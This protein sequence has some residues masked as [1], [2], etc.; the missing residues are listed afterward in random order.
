MIGNNIVNMVSTVHS[1]CEGEDVKVNRRRSGINPVNK[2]NVANVWGKQHRRRIFI[3][4]ITNDYNH[5]INGVDITDQLIANYR[6][7]IRCR[8]TWMP[9]MF[10][11]LN[12]L[13]INMFIAHHLILKKK[14]KT[15]DTHKP[16]IMEL[17]AALRLQLREAMNVRK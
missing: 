5:C 11:S 8:R 9:L 15:N 13:R 12:I 1:G 2:N 3:S 4:V 14:I 16:F 17:V 7:K 10:H 6:P